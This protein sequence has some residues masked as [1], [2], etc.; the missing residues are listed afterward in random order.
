MKITVD[1]SDSHITE[2]DLKDCNDLPKLGCINVIQRWKSAQKVERGSGTHD[3]MKSSY[4]YI[5][6]DILIKKYYF[7]PYKSYYTYRK[8]F[9]FGPFDT[10][11]DAAMWAVGF[12][13][14]LQ[15]FLLLIYNASLFI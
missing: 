12:H 9:S 6:F 10:F 7:Y 3:L 1:V 13:D 2:E 4:G 8:E 5:E 11:T 14:K 15:S